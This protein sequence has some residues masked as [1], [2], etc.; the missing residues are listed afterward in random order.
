MHHLAISAVATALAIG[1]GA[2]AVTT[3]GGRDFLPPSV[4]SDVA[5]PA[6]AG[7][8]MLSDSS[9]L[10]N[11]QRSPVNTAFVS[12][13]K[14]A[15]LSG[16]LD[17]K[18][19]YTV[20]APTDQAYAA[21]RKPKDRASAARDAGY[22]VVKGRYDSQ[23]LLKAIGEGGGQAKL[24]TMEGGTIVAGLNGPTNIS[25][26]D[27]NGNV[28]DIAIYDIHQSNGVMQIVDRVLQPGDNTR[29]VAAR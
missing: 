12:E 13:V 25:L 29:W 26:M 16:T 6:V 18:G 15:G 2:G 28:A 20:F 1:A 19:E 21:A 5:N 4:Q 8:A 10:A 24:R 7:Q 17:G 23:A 11:A 14:A 27:E 3:M 22:L 9:I